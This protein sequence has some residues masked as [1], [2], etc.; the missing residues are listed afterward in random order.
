MASAIG[1]VME[2]RSLSV[3]TSV[4]RTANEP[5]GIDASARRAP[6]LVHAVQSIRARHGRILVAWAFAVNWAGGWRLTMI[7]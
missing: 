7:G 3:V 6:R 2:K 4:M 1:V 5:P